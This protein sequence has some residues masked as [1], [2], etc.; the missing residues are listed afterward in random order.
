MKKLVKYLG[1]LSLVLLGLSVATGATAVAQQNQGGNGYYGYYGGSGCYNNSYAGSSYGNSCAGS[2]YGNSCAGNYYGISP[3][4][5]PSSEYCMRWISGRWVPVTVM[6]PGRWV[7]RPVWIPGYP[8]TLYRP[9]P[10]YWQQTVHPASPDLSVWQT[11]NGWY[12]TPSYQ[13][14]SGSGYFDNYGVWHP[15]R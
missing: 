15:S 5:R 6:V 1:V 14:Q 3:Y 12:G 4:P 9:I 13:G 11:P 10:G 2:Y 8:I 7:Y